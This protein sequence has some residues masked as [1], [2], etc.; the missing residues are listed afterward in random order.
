[1]TPDFE[2]VQVVNH[3][4]HG[5]PLPL[6]LLRLDGGTQTRAA[7]DTD[8][9]AEY[10]EAMKAGAS[11]PPVVV[12]HD[13]SAYWLA[14]G[15]HRVEAARQAGMMS[16]KA[17]IEAGSNRDACLY[18]IGA[19]QAH[20]LRRTNADKRRA[21]QALLNDSEWGNWS[22]REIAKRCGVSHPF[23]AKLRRP[24]SGNV[25]G[26]LPPPGHCS[27]GRAFLHGA[28]WDAFIMPSKSYKA[29]DGSWVDG[30]TYLY[31]MCVKKDLQGNDECVGLKKPLRRDYVLEI[32]EDEGFPFNV[33]EWD[34]SPVSDESDDMP[35]AVDRRWSWPHLLYD[36][37]DQWKANRWD[38]QLGA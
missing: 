29:W 14:D 4:G 22:D 1:M 3:L 21:V 18:A 10:A 26:P 23:V 7:L 33:A 12:F 24:E 36:S 6:T 9:A 17:T 11:F 38:L 32:L 5:D 13:G 16:I 15:F 2:C 28:Q 8:T 37:I 19:N 20:G 31:V 35:W 30:D 27:I 34:H 25:S